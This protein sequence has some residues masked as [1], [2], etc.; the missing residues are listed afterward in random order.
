MHATVLVVLQ[1]KLFDIASE[2]DTGPT[3]NLAQRMFDW[4]SSIIIFCATRNTRY[5]FTTALIYHLNFL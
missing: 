2:I 1:Q 4:H 5:H 3:F